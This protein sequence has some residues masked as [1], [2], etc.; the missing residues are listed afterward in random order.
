MFSGSF[1]C[2]FPSL[3]FSLAG[4][5]ADHRGSL[6]PVCAGSMG[7]NGSLKD[8]RSRFLGSLVLSEL[9]NS[10]YIYIATT[11]THTHALF[12]FLSLSLSSKRSTSRMFLR[13]V[14][15]RLSLSRFSLLFFISVN[16]TSLRC[17]WKKMLSFLLLCSS[18]Y[19][20]PCIQRSIHC[21]ES[22]CPSV[23][24]WSRFLWNLKKYHNRKHRKIL[25]YSR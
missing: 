8:G 23:V 2:A 19:I 22:R 12:S 5:V 17:L 11:L 9:K 4:I 18:M 10:F 15:R 25:K 20:H 16:V 13:S 24:G 6:I 14:P 21:S 1:L 3:S 7:W